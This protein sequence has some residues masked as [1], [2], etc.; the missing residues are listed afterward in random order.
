MKLLH[1]VTT[2]AS[3]H[4]GRRRC[5]STQSQ[6]SAKSLRLHELNNFRNFICTPRTFMGVLVTTGLSGKMRTSTMRLPHVGQAGRIKTPRGL[7][8]VVAILNPTNKTEARDPVNS[9]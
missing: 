2:T 6:R 1:A 9:D 8:V 4:F 3:R 7:P 5:Q